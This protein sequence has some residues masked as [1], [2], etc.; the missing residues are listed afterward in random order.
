[1]MIIPAAGLGSRLGVPVPKALAPVA[2]R[3]MI[4]HLFELYG[5]TMQRFV[6]VVSPAGHDLVA[7]HLGGR[8]EV[9]DLAVQPEPTGMLDAVLLACDCVR[10]HQPDRVWITWCDQ[11]A[12]HTSTVSR[13]IEA[14]TAP[15]E[16][17]MVVPT[18]PGSN[19]YIHFDRDSSGRI[20]AVRQRREGDAMPAVGESDMGLFSLSRSAYLEDLRAYDQAAGRGQSTRE[21]N[22]LP[23]IP[24]LASCRRVVTFPCADPIEAVGINTPEELHRVEA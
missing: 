14:E 17:A 21:R 15:S 22:F 13:I 9:V 6:V 8:L 5:G 16:P 24:W 19:P 1:M 4:D 18:C 11:L 10:R 20:V 3:P 2:G 23:F 12:I 7:G